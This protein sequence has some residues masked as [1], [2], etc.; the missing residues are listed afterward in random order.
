ML[1]RN[2]KG[3]TL[4]EIIIGISL[5]AIIVAILL[6]AFRLG[7]R[8]Q[9]KSVWRDE[10]AQ[11]M[12]ILNDRITW[13]LRGAYP[14]IVAK[15]EGN[16]LYFSGSMSSVGFVTTSVEQD[17]QELEDKAGLK[18]IQIFS[19]SDGLKVR[20]KIYFLED[21]F[22]DSGG[23]V[24]IID[25]SVDSIEFSYFDVNKKE[26]TEDWVSTWEPKDKNYIPS[27]VKVKMEFK[28]N[29]MRFKVPEFVVKLSG[30]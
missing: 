28:Y 8:S 3:L 22:D 9:E 23:R 12:R 7:Y 20:E 17:S 15:S 5:S 29:G 30:I 19:D 24:Y 14:Y 10:V 26:K 18:W 25:P 4:I 27:A 16:V 2:N 13:L 11:K 6:A 1:L 21:V